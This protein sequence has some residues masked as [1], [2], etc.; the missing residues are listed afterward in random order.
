MGQRI[1]GI[2]QQHV[3]VGASLYV[4]LVV[5]CTRAPDDGQIICTV[6]KRTVLDPGPDDVNSMRGG[7]VLW[8]NQQR[9]KPI[10][11]A[12]VV[13]AGAKIAQ[14]VILNVGQRI[15]A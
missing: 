6:R 5:A 15:E 11:I 8:R 2:E 10:P 3:I 7:N 9:V 1:R 12:W 13:T 14:V 4:D